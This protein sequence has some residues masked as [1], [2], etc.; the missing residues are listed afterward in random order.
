[1]KLHRDLGMTQKTAWMMAQKIREGWR[2]GGRLTGEIEIDETY[3]GGRERNKHSAKRLRAGRGPVGKV[4]VI[5]AIQR[6][7]QVVARPIAETDEPTLMGFVSETVSPMSTIY[8]DGSTSYH[9]ADGTYDHHVVQHSRGEYVRGRAHTNAIESFWSLL[10]RA[11]KGTFHK[12]SPKHLHRYV[13]EFAGR[14]NVRDLDTITQMEL[15][16]RGLDGK[17]LPWKVLTAGEPGQAV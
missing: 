8:T 9:D 13:T 12:M 2:Q 3:V 17:Q 1:M 15:L 14:H 11:H 10:K 7:G 6:G 5:G 4:A 16:A